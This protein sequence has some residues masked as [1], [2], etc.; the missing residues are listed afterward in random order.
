MHSYW[1]KLKATYHGQ[2]NRMN[3]CFYESKSPAFRYR[4]CNSAETKCVVSFTKLRSCV[5]RD[6][7]RV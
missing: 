6:A 2:I 7:R 3:T 4:V 1:I 5:A